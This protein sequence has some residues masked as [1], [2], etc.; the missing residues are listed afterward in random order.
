MVTLNILSRESAMTGKN[1]KIPVL[2]V[3]V[4]KHVKIYQSFLWQWSVLANFPEQMDGRLQLLSSS[5]G[6]VLTETP[7]EQRSDETQTQRYV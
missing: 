6:G 3:A 7:S 5:R 4:A 1:I 2:C